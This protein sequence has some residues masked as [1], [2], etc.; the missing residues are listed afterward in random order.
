MVDQNTMRTFE[1]EVF[2][3]VSNLTL[4]IPY[5]TPQVCIVF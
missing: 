2:F 3:L 4:Q 5:I 1:E